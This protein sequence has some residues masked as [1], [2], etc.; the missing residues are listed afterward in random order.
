M[1]NDSVGK[2]GLDLELQADIGKQIQK[3]A[4]NLGK[5]LEQTIKNSGS[6]GIENML[7]V[8]SRHLDGVFKQS[9]DSMS[10][11]IDIALRKM[12]SV[13]MPKFEIPTNQTFKA[14]SI[15][16]AKTTRGPPNTE[17]I[18]AEMENVEAMMDNIESKIAMQKTKLKGLKEAYINTFDVTKKS[19]IEDNMLRVESVIIRLIGQMDKLGVKYNTLESKMK[20]A[21][22]TVAP[23][24]PSTQNISVGNT[25][26]STSTVGKSLSRLGN[27]IKNTNSKFANFSKN[28]LVF[29]K[30]TGK[31]NKSVNTF[32]SGIGNSIKQMFKWMILFPALVSGIM[33]LAR[34]LGQSLMVNE[35]FARSFNQ[36]K[37][38]L[39]VAFT[40]IYQ[41]ILPAINTLMS[42][43]ARLS[44]YF[45]SF[46]SQLFGKTYEQSFNAT[47]Q[48]T[49]AKDA[50]GA[51]GNSTKKAAK[52][53]KEAQK[54][55]LG[56]DE[57]NKLS[58]N[59]T[60][61]TA[62]DSNAPVL[63]EPDVNMATLD[64]KT[65]P[66]VEK[67]K[68]ILSK[69]FLPFKQSWAKEGQ[70]TITS[71]KGAF[72]SILGLWGSIGKSFLDV[73]TNGSGTQALTT[74]YI[75][76]QNVFKVVGNIADRF[77]DAWNA[78]NTGTAIIQT[79][80]NMLNIVLSTIQEITSATADWAATVD[81]SPILVAL[82]GLLEALEP[83]IQIIGDKLV[84][85]WQTHVL[86][87]F[88]WLIEKAIP[89][90]LDWLTNLFN[91][92]SEHQGVVETITTAVV[93]FFVAFKAAS[94]IMS[95]I[96]ALGALTSA[97]NPV[98]LGI[99]AVIAIGILL[100]Q[101]WDT[102]CAKA[103]EIWEK[104]T[105]IFNKSCDAICTK[106][107]EIW[108]K[109]TD[110]FNNFT[111]FMKNAFQTDFTKSFGAFGDILNSFFHTVQR[112]WDSIKD[113]F[114]GIVN[115]IK[116]VFTGNWKQAWEGVKD[117]FKGVFNGMDAFL[118]A[119]LNAAIGMLNGMITGLNKIRL[120]EWVP[121]I[122]GKGINI[123]KIPYLAKGG[124]IDSPTLAMVGEQGK[125]AVVPLENN[126]GWISQLAEKIG[127]GGVSD[128]SLQEIIKLLVEL[129]TI[130]KGNDPNTYLD[131]KIITKKVVEN[132]NK[133]IMAKG[134]SP[135]LI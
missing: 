83:V 32:N 107:K 58:D 52:A 129:I 39:S 118:K 64:S 55:L 79:I 124:I 128:A 44:S 116:G 21:G 97:F 7:N 68:A 49:S 91:F 70:S 123:P 113:I 25:V 51:Y 115:F 16:N 65:I 33:A 125:E 6:A 111:D 31:A 54:D 56:F 94:I 131:G 110:I 28:M 50:M 75:I 121:G 20:S 3:A 122:G 96:K 36:I 1:A 60:S 18:K 127:T 100:W 47:K 114:N 59:S 93:T 98:L 73:W 35:Q 74:I 41:A 87:F 30:N 14:T 26:N 46:I 42:A 77:S 27:I 119:P 108:G 105:D 24:V 63:I 23:T 72:N 85:I 126:T 15:G 11:Q 13:K 88:T 38:N 4:S 10:K 132:I 133:E 2:I 134:K 37:T 22:T 90:V 89:T 67:F 29:S 106:V 8:F 99:A 9:I 43:L 66:W 80:F 17:S 135:I 69:I 61:D 103:K 102:I 112:I 82:M 71:M 101:N 81:F 48:L 45:A 78:N 12:T 120:P 19:K 76:L 34:S 95:V 5:Q 109:I 40:P 84:D 53:A 57:I 117:I 86:P 104:I 62:S 130:I 92:L